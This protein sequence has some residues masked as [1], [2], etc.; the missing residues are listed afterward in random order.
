MASLL[1]LDLIIFDLLTRQ[2]HRLRLMKNEASVTSAFTNVYSA[3]KVAKPEG[4]S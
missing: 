2:D 3:G 4:K 1:T